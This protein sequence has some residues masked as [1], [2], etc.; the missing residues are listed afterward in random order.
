MSEH[1]RAKWS[2]EHYEALLDFW[3]EAVQR[4]IHT[5]E[6]M[7]NGKPRYAMYAQESADYLNG[8]CR[9]K[10]SASSVDG[11]RHEFFTKRIYTHVKKDVLD[12]LMP[13]I[14]KL[15]TQFDALFNKGWQLKERGHLVSRSK[16]IYVLSEDTSKKHDLILTNMTAEQI[17]RLDEKLKTKTSYKGKMYRYIPNE[18]E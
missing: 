6:F 10:Y 8:K 13:R 17:E 12:A 18:K 7:K 2:R 3:E 1:G 9:T 5:W 14:T 11:K 15:L 4:P 16:E